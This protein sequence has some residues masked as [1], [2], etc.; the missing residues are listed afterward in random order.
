LQ[1]KDFR[2]GIKRKRYELSTTECI[3]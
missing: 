3:Y 2:F 1:C